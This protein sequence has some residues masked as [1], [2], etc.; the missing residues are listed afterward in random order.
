M[1]HPKASIPLRNSPLLKN[2][3]RNLSRA[4]NGTFAFT[5]GGELYTLKEGQAPQKIMITGNGGFDGDQVKMI[6][7]KGEATDMAVS[8]DAKE[9]AFVYRGRD[10]CCRSKWLLN[11]KDH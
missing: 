5:Q 1:A 10:L 3:V 2:T 8:P 11:K 6:P 4:D 9:V 7:V